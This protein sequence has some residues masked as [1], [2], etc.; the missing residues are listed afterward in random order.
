MNLL[1]HHDLGYADVFVFENYLINQIKEGA[2]I[3]DRHYY[4]L[5]EMIDAHFSDRAMV[6]LSNRVNS[7]SVDPLIHTNVSTIENLLGL[8]I[9]VDSELRRESA[10]FEGKFSKKPYE[11]FSTLQEAI[12]WATNILKENKG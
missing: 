2:R 3:S 6:Y 11:V 1:E 12:I 10:I 5:K 9:V 8:G 7:Y 4:V